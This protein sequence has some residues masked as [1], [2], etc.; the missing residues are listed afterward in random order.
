MLQDDQRALMLI[1]MTSLLA[2]PMNFIVLAI[3][4]YK[5]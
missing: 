2:H 4:G 5:I 3:S 1:A